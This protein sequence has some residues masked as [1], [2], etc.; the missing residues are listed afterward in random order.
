MNN[1]ISETLKMLRKNRKLSQA[2]LGKEIGVS[3][4]KISSWEIGRRDI[5]LDDAIIIANYFEI[6]LDSL[7]NADKFKYEIDKRIL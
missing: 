5:S 3:R 2:R 4:S 1:N 7:V 6:T